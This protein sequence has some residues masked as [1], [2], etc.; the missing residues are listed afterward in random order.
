MQWKKRLNGNSTHIRFSDDDV[1]PTV[2]ADPVH[3][4]G[5]CLRAQDVDIVL[6]AGEADKP[7]GG[8]KGQVVLDLRL[9]GPG[10]EEGGH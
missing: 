6:K 1:A 2:T 4:L 5:S 8:P 9:R 10:P 7:V 3:L